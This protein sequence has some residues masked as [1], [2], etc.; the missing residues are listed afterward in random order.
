MKWINNG[1]ENTK[2]T[3]RLIWECS[4][5]HAEFYGDNGLNPPEHDC[6]I[7]KEEEDE[8]QDRSDV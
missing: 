3:V 8:T 1:F 2:G 4:N 7:C 5:C 6:P